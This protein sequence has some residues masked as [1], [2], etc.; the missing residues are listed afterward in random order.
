VTDRQHRTEAAPLVNYIL[1]GVNVLVFVF[2]QGCGTRP[3]I[4][5]SYALIPREIIT[6]QD[7]DR[8]VFIQEP[9]GKSV[10]SI[11]LAH[12]PVTVYITLLTSMF[13]HGGLMHLFA[14]LSFLFTFG[15]KVESRLG[16][17]M[18]FIF[19]LVCGVSAAFAHVAM[20]P[21]SF[22]PLL[23]ASGAISGVLGGYLVLFPKSR[24][25][26]PLFGRLAFIPAY[27]A[28]GLFCLFQLVSGLG[29]LGG[30]SQMDGVGYAAHVGGFVVGLLFAMKER[31]IHPVVIEA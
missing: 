26:A 19:Y 29:L 20:N 6:G 14:N 9:D 11:E 18:Y 31:L 17:V 27:V 4:V 21:G 23:G 25:R 5:G 7:I 16:H 1:A 8:T 2:F 15:I 12:T 3:S 28:I 24:V 30:G 13:M 10:G 22:I